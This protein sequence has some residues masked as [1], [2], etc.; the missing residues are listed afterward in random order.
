[1]PEDWSRFLGPAVA[2]GGVVAAL[3]SYWK[4]QAWKRQ[5]FLAAQFDQLRSDERSRTAMILLD[6]GRSY[7]ELPFDTPDEKE[8]LA[9]ADGKTKFVSIG[10]TRLAVALVPHDRRG[11]LGN[12]P[13]HDHVR[14]CIDELLMKLCTF[15]LMIDKKL[16]AAKDVHD[17]LGYWIEVV[18][19]VR[20]RKS[21]QNRKDVFLALRWHVAE[22]GFGDV[23]DLARGYGHDLSI[24]DEDKEA[25]LARLASRAR[26]PDRTG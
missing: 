8:T 4:T 15:Q 20:A 26:D 1:M 10:S 3:I 14:L 6:Q 21:S 25:L 19:G 7:V 24:T 11:G 5:E 2:F 17:Y 18:A 22:Y 23:Q 9:S 13:V 16:A 12:T